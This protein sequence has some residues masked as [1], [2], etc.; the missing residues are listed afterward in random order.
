MIPYWFLYVLYV[1]LGALISGAFYFLSKKKRRST[2]KIGCVAILLF[3]VITALHI[4]NERTSRQIQKNQ[5]KYSG[6]LVSAKEDGDPLPKGAPPD[7]VQLLLG[8]DLRV[9]A[10]KSENHILSCKGKPFLSIKIKDGR[11]YL[12]ATIVDSQNHN[13]VKIIDN[14]FQV[15]T[16]NAFNPKQPDEHSLLVRDTNGQEVLNLR[17]INE[18]VVWMIGRFHVDNFDGPIV[19]DRV[20]GISWPNGGIGHLTLDLTQSNGGFIEFGK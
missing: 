12:S 4:Y 8:D 15:N 13:I 19:I 2:L 5:P 6:Y 7:T 17:F 1:L 11:L 14:E 10:A 9:L 18:K 20:E 16:E 3:F